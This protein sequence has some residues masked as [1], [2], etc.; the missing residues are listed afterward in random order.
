MAKLEEL[1]EIDISG[2]K[3]KAIPTTIMNCRRMHTVVAHSNCIEVFPEVMQ[4][5][6][7]KVRG[8]TPWAPAV[9]HQREALSLIHQ[10]RT[11]APLSD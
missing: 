10:F 1:E 2:N 3:L 7:I 6:E 9:G 11:F 4:L 5:P 8:L